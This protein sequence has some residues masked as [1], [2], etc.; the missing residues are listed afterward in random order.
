MAVA[1]RRLCISGVVQGVGFRPFVYRQAVSLGLSGFV[2]N[3]QDGVFVEVEGPVADLDE[4][5]ARLRHPPPL[6]AVESVETSSL[7]VV[8]GSDFIILPTRHGGPAAV[9]VP[10]DLATCSACLAEMCDPTD[11]RFEYPFINCTDCGPRYT[12]IEAVPYARE[13]T[14]MSAFTMCDACR[15]EFEDPMQRRFHAEPIACPECGPRLVLYDSDGKTVAAEATAVGAAVDLLDGGGIIAVKGLGGYHLAV[16]AQNQ[17]A[18]LKLRQRKARD[19]KP[20][21]VMVP[22]LEWARRISA[23]T[24][25]H[26]A[27]LLSVRR[28][29]VLTPRRD[30]TCLADAV[31]PN[32][33][34]VGVLLPY[35][36]L[37]HLL[38]ERFGRPL[39]MTSGNLTDEPIAH[40]DDDA[41]QRLGPLVDAMLTHDRPIRVRAD[42]SV[43]RISPAT[44]VQLLRR[45]RGWAPESLA[46]PAS[47]GWPV[48]AVG[49]QLKNTVA[50]A[51]GATVVVSH[52]VGDLDHLAAHAAFTAAVD[53][54]VALT[55]VRPAAVAHDLHPDYR[56]TSYAMS[57]DL[58]SVAVQH[59]H[60]HVASCLVDNGVAGPVVGVA[61][62][63]FGYGRDGAPWGGELLIADLYGFQRV[64]H[65]RGVPL[66]GGDRAA[67]E[68]W[69]MALAWAL[70]SGGRDE[71]AA[72]GPALDPRWEPVLGLIESAGTPTTT[73]AGRLFDAAASLVGLRHYVSYEGQAAMEF[74]A[75]AHSVA[76]ADAPRWSACVDDSG[77]TVV[78]DPRPL[79]RQLMAGMGSREPISALSAGFHFGLGRTVADAAALVADRHGIGSV[80]LTGGVFQNMRLTEVVSER[81]MERGL[82]VLLHSHVPANDGGISVGQAA[83]A[84]ALGAQESG[85]TPA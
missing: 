48:I 63:G 76:P 10:A 37:H 15:A 24:A 35:T 17:A 83:I 72:I 7:D 59:H 61:F 43:V 77:D 39:V 74:E 45:S 31:A 26:E 55:G 56:S 21:A 8:G 58:P 85:G 41:A 50:L 54:L 46:L 29:I 68:P 27:A 40:D 2:G 18:L 67:R 11:R 53:H 82:R 32:L 62:D 33:I 19:D 57:L 71:A 6:A 69:R 16:D 30:G 64:G 14:T 80:A 60:A 73:S 65:I 36:P 5:E 52:H 79:I 1:R 42:D 47:A 34:E 38:V 4:L 44:G 28:P 25:A 51:A 9:A 75:A 78:V 66:P 3:D 81:L 84:A 23:M 12:I 13:R 49:A 70:E 22:D 20:F